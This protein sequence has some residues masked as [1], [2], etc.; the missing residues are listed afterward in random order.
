MTLPLHDRFP[1]TKNLAHVTLGCLPTPVEPVAE[2]AR[3]L[4]I[5]SF[6]VKRDDI[7]GRTYGGNKVRK[8]EFLLGQALAENRRAV[9]TFGAV[10]SNH[11]RATSV[12]GGQVGLQV[13]AVLAP[14]PSTPYLDANLRAD[15]AAGA[16]LHFVESYAQALTRGAELRDQITLRDGAEPFVIPFGGT[17]PRGI[18]GFVNAAIELAGQVATG[19]LP[20]PDLIYVPYGS[21]GTAGGLAI[22]LA[23]VGLRTSVI[24]VRVVP[25]ESTNPVR[26]RRVMEE[27]VA[28]LRELDASFPSLKPE[29]V[30]LEVRDGFLGEEYAA[31]TTK[32]L[33]AVALA[34]A[35]GVH[36]ETTYTGKAL[37]A[38]IADARAGN[39]ADKT[40]LFWN[41]Y[42]STSSPPEVSCFSQR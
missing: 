21:A 19:A 42:S 13:H 8:L 3:L 27:A 25:A 30:A 32:G 28:L 35:S 5:S 11:V 23:A 4:G 9:I 29:S 41:T 31:A 38:L 40:V 22:G 33:E 39:L 24:G 15:R 37:A 1:G 26:T 6:F 12:Y 10:G 36:L 17:N 18:I 16:T 2:L 7:S 34:E 20:E 14:Q